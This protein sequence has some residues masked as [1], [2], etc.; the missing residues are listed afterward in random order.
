MDGRLGSRGSAEGREQIER[1]PSCGATYRRLEQLRNDLQMQPPRYTA[2]AHLQKRIHVALRKAAENEA[3]RRALPWNW[4][5]V[6]A[7]VLL[8]AS[9]AWNFALLRSRGPATGSLAQEVLS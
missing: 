7:S 4:A 6:A 3:P 8:C 5:A 2:S 9:L 1:W